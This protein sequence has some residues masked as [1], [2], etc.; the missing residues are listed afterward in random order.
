[1]N[2]ALYNK[3]IRGTTNWDVPIMRM[4]GLSILAATGGRGGDVA[5]SAGYVQLECLC[6]KDV[7]VFWLVPPSPNAST[8]ELYAALT[9]RLTLRF[10]KGHK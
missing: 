2:Y 4:L 10:T 1:M 6:F 3:A 5:R 9:V 8:K 7:E